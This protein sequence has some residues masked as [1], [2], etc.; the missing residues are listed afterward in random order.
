MPFIELNSPHFY[1]QIAIS[2]INGFLLCLC[3]YKFLQ[4]IQLTGYKVKGF[5]I[6]L[7]DTKGKYYIRLFMLSLI[8]IVCLI[9]INV[10]VESF[11]ASEYFSYIGL[12]FYFYFAIFFGLRLNNFEKKTPLKYTHRMDR[13]IATLMI[14]ASFA[15]FCILRGGYLSTP[16]IKFSL[17]AITP[18]LLIVFV[19]MSF[20]IILPYELLNNA[21]FILQAKNK[22]KKLEQKNNLIK[23]AVTGSYGKTTVK[24]F[25]S[26]ILSQ[27]YKVCKSPLSYNT[28]MG[29]T[30]TILKNLEETDEVIICEMGA[31]RK[32]DIKK[33][34]D[35][36]NPNYGIL[37]SI[38]ECHLETFKS[39]ETIKN[40]KFELIAALERNNGFAVFGDDN[41]EIKDLFNK[42]KCS[43]INVG[44][45]DENNIFA[46]NIKMSAKGTSF[47]LVV[48]N[49]ASN[50]KTKLLGIHNVTNILLAVGIA[51]KLGLS[52]DEIKKGIESLEPVEHR[53]SIIKGVN[54]VTI[55]D[56]GY[57]SN[58]AGCKRALEV[59]N[60]FEGRKV[61][62]TPGL[63]ELGTE[64]FNS[65]FEFGK[66]IAS[67][68]DMAIIVNLANQKALLQGLNEGG[69]KEENIFV[70]T[71]LNM[72]KDIMSKHLREGD[73]LLIEN[74]LPD[75][76]S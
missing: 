20:Y 21:R 36:V 9:T 6:W 63:V 40:T 57:N 4:V 13:L 37:T 67:N 23:I 52:I 75:N 49:E 50:V 76:Y 15:T 30:K 8:S 72:A 74:D 39:V 64:Q 22:L 28:P 70:V 7:K 66:S 11:G 71:S 34:C 16:I 54:N 60:M 14:V 45:T 73:N 33:L 3:G 56:D 5:F 41:K 19:P 59:L 61:V 53:L 68:A 62:L 42:A 25:L 55:L 35:I 27:K 31:R 47:D 10:L 17:V 46:R 48:N 58:L 26:T 69:M 24:N 44:L 51:N 2:L 18:L 29:I 38:G 43:K 65:N 32:N 12:I 1:I